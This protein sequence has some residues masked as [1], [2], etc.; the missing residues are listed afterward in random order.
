VFKNGLRGAPVKIAILSSASAGGAGI[1][2][3][4]IYQAFVTISGH[5]VDFFD[6]TSL[7]QVNIEVSPTDSATNGKITNTHFTIDYASDTR[8]WVIDLLMDYD[9]INVQWA[10]YLV[11]LSEIQSLAKAGKKILFTM[12]DFHYITGGCHYPAGCTGFL[13]NCVGCPQVNEKVLS[14]QTV[15]ATN[16]L[17]REIFSY[18]NVHLSAPSQFIVDSAI[19]SGIVPPGRAHVLR[20]AYEPVCDFEPKDNS[21]NN[22]K[23]KAILLIAD[24]FDEKRKGLALAVDSLKIAAQDFRKNNNKVTLHL[25]GGLDSEVIKRLDGTGIKVVTHGHIKEHTKLVDIFKQCQFMLSC[26]YEDNWPNILVE[27]GSYGCIPIVG[28]WHGCEEF[29]N[30]LGLG[31]VASH[32]TAEQYAI[33]INQ[34]LNTSLDKAL[35]A[36]FVK[37][38]RVMHAPKNVVENY[39]VVFNQENQSVLT[40]SS[41]QETHFSANYLAATQGV[42]KTQCQTTVISTVESPFGNFEHNVEFKASKIGWNLTVENNKYAL[43]QNHYG[44]SNFKI[45]L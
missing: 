17:K 18:A 30:A 3:Y 9:V 16:K 32:Y 26:S 21:K 4:R 40:S 13:K 5:E 15:M 41:K 14:Q 33:A 34:A 25:V 1:A 39:R 43:N 24:S 19:R 36:D 20:N 35:L 2:A 7:G 45:K 23:D 37:K 6:M 44:L 31:Y 42:L 29:V 22:S 27:A 8:Q 11:S 10:S 12:H 28:K 38:V